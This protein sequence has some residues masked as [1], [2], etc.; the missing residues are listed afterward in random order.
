MCSLTVC[1]W[2]NFSVQTELK[3]YLSFSSEIHF[4]NQNIMDGGAT[5][6]VN[7]FLLSLGCTSFKFYLIPSY[8]YYRT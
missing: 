1:G 3:C 6:E 7:N 2:E 5:I 8:E 4:T